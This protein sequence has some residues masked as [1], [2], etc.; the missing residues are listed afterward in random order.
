MHRS[1]ATQIFV[2]ACSSS[3]YTTF[4]EVIK[5]GVLNK[6]CSIP[7][8]SLL[9]KFSIIASLNLELHLSKQT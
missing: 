7:N 9:A 6:S 5:T 1:Y 4:K 8:Q 3:F 2:K